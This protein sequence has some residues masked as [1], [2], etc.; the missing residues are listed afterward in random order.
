MR[1]IGLLFL[2][3]LAASVQAQTYQWANGLGSASNDEVTS[4]AYD[5]SGNT[6]VSGIHRGTITT[7]SLTNAG[8]EDAFVFKTD[9]SGAIL[10]Q[11]QFGKPLSDKANAMVVDNAGNVYLTG[12][13]TG[14][15]V[16]FKFVGG[17]DMTSQ[18]AGSSADIYLVKY[19]SSGTFQW[20]RGIGSASTDEGLG[21]S[22]D[23]SG[24]LVLCGFIGGTA[25]VY[26]KATPSIAT[27][28]AI[29]S[30]DAVVAKFAPDGSFIW[31]QAIGSAAGA[32]KAT[33]I[34]TDASD[35]V[36]VGGLVFGTVD[37][38]PGAGTANV[39][40]GIPQG[41]GD[42]YLAKYSSA[43]VYQWGGSMIGAGAEQISS[44]SVSGSHVYAAG[45]FNGFVDFNILGGVNNLT[46]T[47]GKDIFFARYAVAD[48]AYGYAQKLG[49]TLDDEARKIMVNASSDIYLT[50]YFSGTNI[51]FDPSAGSSLLT[52]AGGF[53]IFMAKFTSTPTL[54]WA[55][56][57][58][59]ATQDEGY[60]I[61]LDGSGNIYLGGTY[62]NNATDFDN[63][64]GTRT[65]T[66]NGLRDGLYAKYVECSLPSITSHPANLSACT[67]GNA[68]LTVTASGAGLT[69]Q[70][71]KGGVDLTNGGAI[72]GATTNALA[73]TGLV[74]GDAGNYRCVVT[75]CGTPV[76]S[77]VAVLT[78]NSGPAITTQP[79]SQN[80][81]TGNPVSFTVVATGTGITY[82][83]KKNGSPMSNGGTISGVA[84]ATLSISSTVLADAAIYTCDIGSASC[85]TPISTNAATLSINIPPSI[86]AQ[87]SNQTL[88][89]GANTS[90][91]V[92][93]SGST[94][95]YQWQKN[96]VDIGNGGSISGA[97][98]ATISFTSALA[99]DAANYRCV[100]TGFCTPSVTSNNATLTVNTSPT[101]TVQPAPIT[102]CAGAVANFSVTA[103]GSGLSYQWQKDAVN[104]VNGGGISGA[105]SATL[106]ISGVSAASAGNYRCIV[107]GLC[108]PAVNSNLAALTV[109]ALPSI[110]LQPIST[111]P[112]AGQNTSFTIAAAGTAITYQWQKNGSP[113]S[114]GGSISGATTASLSITGVAA[115]DAGNYTCVVSGTCSPSVTS[116]AAVLAVG[117]LAAITTQPVNSTVCAGGLVT[118]SIVASGTG[119]LY[120]W[121][122]GGIDLINGGSISGATS[123]TLSI[124]G[125]IAG[126][127]GNYRCVISNGCTALTPSNVAV[128][129]V[130]SPPTIS[131]NPVNANLCEGQNANFTVTAS[132][133]T[134]TYQWQ[135]NSVALS[136]G[137]TIAGATSA[138][139]SITGLVSA[140][141]GTYRCVVSGACTPVATST[142]AVLTVGSVVAI[143]GQPTGLTRCAGTS[144]SFTVSNSGL[145]ALYVWKKNGVALT[146]GGTISGVSTA[147]LSISSVIA[148][149]AGNYTC[150]LSNGCTPT[151]TSSI[152]ALVVESLPAISVQPLPLAECTGN[153]AVFAVTATGSGISYQWRK[154]GTPLTNGGSISGATT[155]S[156]TVSSLV[157]SDAGI[158]SVVVS[159]TCTPSV[160]STGAALTVGSVGAITLD[161]VDQTLCSGVAASMSI[162]HS[163]SGL[164]YQWRKGGI[165]LTNG[166][167]LSGATSATLTIS[168][169]V[170]SDAGSYTCEISNGC[171]PVEVSTAALLTVNAL[172]TITLNPIDQNVCT[173]ANIQL[174]VAGTGTALSYSWSKD[175]TPLSDGGDISGS[176][177]STLDI[178][179][180]DASDIG[181]YTCTISGTCI[182]S[183]TSSAAAVNVGVSALIVSQPSST[184]ACTGSNTSFSVT[185]SG[186]GL[187]YQWFKD[188]SP[189][190]NGGVFSGTT[191]TTLTLSSI[192]ASEIGDYTVEVS[193]TCGAPLTSAIASLSLGG[194]SASIT[195]QPSNVSPCAGSSVTISIVAAGSGLN[196]QWQKG[197][198]PLV[199]GGNI[200]GAST[201]DLTI[202]SAST[203]DEGTY[204]CLVSGAC[205][206]PVTS[207]ISVLAIGSSPTVTAQPVSANVCLG[208][209]ASFVTTV[210]GGGLSYQWEFRAPGGTYVA[211][212]NG[213]NISG[214]TTNGLVI[215]N[216]QFVNRG[217][218]RCVVSSGCA[219]GTITAVASLN[220]ETPL[221]I[222]EPLSLSICNT[223]T[224]SFNV[225]ALGTNLQYQWYKD[226]APVSNGGKIS[227]AKTATLKITN[228]EPLNFDGDYLCK[229]TGICPPPVDTEVASLFVAL[230]TDVLDPTDT[231]LEIY[232]NPSSGSVTLKVNQIPD[233]IQS[234]S[235][236]D[237]NGLVVWQ[238]NELPSGNVGEIDYQLNALPA[239]MYMM[240]VQ[241]NSAVLPERIEIVK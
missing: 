169:L 33:A 64:A 12:L 123:A 49:G 238:A 236:V 210:S 140:D 24:N 131:L 66:S 170:S 80:A 77:N 226:G 219:G 154:D 133:S 185:A 40:E 136:D 67:G 144:A 229:V 109:N 42:V 96:G 223:Q 119:V 156:L 204:A 58:G 139:L 30:L 94:L 10:W 152:A 53:D 86:S 44:L 220:F 158:Y 234:V 200:S 159:G 235:I 196:Y 111:S 199:D 192:T 174:T 163:G 20:A 176:T 75:G 114:N 130:N 69:Y 145:G 141:A 175:G 217:N 54:T 241:T 88:C 150:E 57:A 137:G 197:G 19:N 13:Y 79:T 125:A 43:G 215:D 207:S 161:P 14:S 23:A 151:I 5:G 46:S 103:T 47:G 164:T 190:A 59:S 93:A 72:S 81:C 26:S 105:T 202:S 41:A 129:T 9:P 95:T 182:P 116:S 4:I 102:L 117:S 231:S 214:A 21:L 135:K 213:G 153:N 27:I 91:S 15:S 97:T 32:E 68:N 233:P 212:V 183:V 227:G 121:Q 56:Q 187:T 107:S 61:N 31:G 198:V 194:S 208:Q 113:I 112:C 3:S 78:V 143:T 168:S 224:A 35:N 160:T 221:I 84:T 171:T 50:G 232:P 85:G 39:T 240:L 132:G 29:G 73:I 222:S 122:K 28:T 228:I 82:A 60:V 70:W 209:Q 106:S 2:L 101:I 173:G 166:G 239:G 51:D 178:V 120:Q 225:V 104:V 8:L 184:S 16:F 172:P 6:Y 186:V 179:N 63:G 142:G 71:Q 155:N 188:S 92:T 177:T 230:C 191:T 165:A 138:A 118:K 62:S 65:L 98:T 89:V 110:S 76:N 18:V 193:S 48:G 55:L 157:L 148:G 45:F 22:F 90:M 128:L 180:A 38:D 126:D 83:W 206:T 195:T 108:L 37:L 189:L 218:Y 203:L 124:T 17:A 52:S 74:L 1:R 100:V 147:T 25:T 167:T 205:G 149:D 87:P 34:T 201:P 11:Q 115:G 237:M 36:Y 216:A 146:N 99:G 181:N 134:L 211:V 127:A 162:T 7:P